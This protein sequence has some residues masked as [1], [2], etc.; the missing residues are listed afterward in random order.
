MWIFKPENAWKSLHLGADLRIPPIYKFIMTYVTPLYIMGIL[1]AWAIQDAI[2]I[3]RL[4]RTTP[5]NAPFIMISRLIMLAF[6]IG[7]LVLIRMAW[8]RNGYKD[9]EGFVEVEENLP[10]ATTKGVAA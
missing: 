9:R 6:I 5:E 10:S 1:I 4:E 8:K 3:L 2:P 7:F